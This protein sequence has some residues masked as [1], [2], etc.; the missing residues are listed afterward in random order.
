MSKTKASLMIIILACAA[1]FLFARGSGEDTATLEQ[2]N[3]RIKVLPE[4]DKN[5]IFYLGVS[6]KTGVFEVQ[7]VDKRWMLIEPKGTPADSEKV[8]ELINRLLNLKAT[9]V[10]E[11]KDFEADLSIYGFDQADMVLVLAEIASDKGIKKNSLIFGRLNPLNNTRYLK[12]VDEKPERVYIIE[13]FEFEFFKINKENVW[14][15]RPLFFKVGDLKELEINEIDK[16]TFSIKKKDDSSFEIET[17][18]NI[19]AADTEIVLKTLTSIAELKINQSPSNEITNLLANTLE[20]PSLVLN[21]KFENGNA[22]SVLFG[23]EVV[24]DSAEE[25]YYFKI[26]ENPLVYRFSGRFLNDLL[27]GMEHFEKRLPFKNLKEE[28]V[29]QISLNAK[30]SSNKA[31]LVND[32]RNLKILNYVSAST[33][34]SAKDPELAI[35][36]SY[37]SGQTDSL[38]IGKS[39]GS[40]QAGEESVDAPR[41][42][43]LKKDGKN[44]TVVLSAETLKGL[45]KFAN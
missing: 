32:L 31:A 42:A 44:H 18:G 23:R 5:L 28:D 24:K 30:P 4:V 2:A 43:L 10:L 20:S 38:Q 26:K 36:I 34:Y 14:D 8:S 27:Q 3:P 11:K 16:R 9:R 19:F 45:L 25:N 17:E 35:E 7:L 22:R 6:H 39:V 29:S 37:F 40:L 33:K 12:I 15:A 41:F 21:F 13:N 1:Y